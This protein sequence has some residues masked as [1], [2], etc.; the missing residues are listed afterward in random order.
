MVK[1]KEKAK[2]RKRTRSQRRLAHDRGD[3]RGPAIATKEVVRP[4][5]P[6]PARSVVDKTFPRTRSPSPHPQVVSFATKLA[7]DAFYDSKD[8]VAV[9]TAGTASDVGKV[10]APSAPS[11]QAREVAEKKKAVLTPRHKS[12][13]PAREGVKALGSPKR[14]K[15]PSPAAARAGPGSEKADAAGKGK[16]GKDKKKK[17]K[18][19]KDGK[20]K[21]RGKPKAPSPLG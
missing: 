13:S 1:A 19:G 17:R 11:L 18:K 2:G 8:E 16:G 15:S 7:E 20:G 5:S 21:G 14:D 9:P 4:P 3:V 12:E 10:S 6:S